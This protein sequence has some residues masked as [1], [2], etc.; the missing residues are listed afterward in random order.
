MWFWIKEGDEMSFHKIYEK[1]YTFFW[2]SRE[3][4]VFLKLEKCFDF[5]FWEITQLVL[6]QLFWRRIAPFE[7]TMTL[8]QTTNNHFLFI[9]QTTA[10]KK[11]IWTLLVV[12]LSTL[13]WWAIVH[14]VFSGIIITSH[15]SQPFSLPN[16][17]KILQFILFHRKYGTNK[18]ALCL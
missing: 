12:L 13:V 11:I 8:T 18:S 14:A 17:K 10:F 1:H 2:A 4:R 7:Q 16:K 15:S 9:E 3:R 6:R 5:N